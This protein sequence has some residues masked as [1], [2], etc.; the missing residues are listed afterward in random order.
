[1]LNIS[2][3]EHLCRLVHEKRTET[4]N[5]DTLLVLLHA[6]CCGHV[7]LIHTLCNECAS[8]PAGVQVLVMVP[9]IY[10]ST[11]GN[12]NWTVARACSSYLFEEGCSDDCFLTK[13]RW[14]Y[15]PLGCILVCLFKYVNIY[16]KLLLGP[17]LV[18]AIPCNWNILIYCE[19]EFGV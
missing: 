1:M 8:E 13:S 12:S 14:I 4:L 16:Q 18:Y 19:G 3:V 15:F 17:Y 7:A 6:Q 10:R 11:S 9:C 2:T 5:N